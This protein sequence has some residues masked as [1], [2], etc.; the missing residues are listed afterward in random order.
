[1]AIEAARTTAAAGKRIVK[2]HLRDVI[3]GKAAVVPIHGSVEVQITLRQSDDATRNF[4]EWCDFRIYLFQGQDSSEAGRGSI[5]L[6][7]VTDDPVGTEADSDGEHLKVHATGHLEALTNCKLAVSS[8]QFYDTL[9]N[10]GLAFGPT[11]RG[12]KAIRCDGKGAAAAHVDPHA[13]TSKLPD[14]LQLNIIHPGS[15]DATLLQAILVV[16]TKGARKRMATMVPTSI[17]RLQISADLY[18]CKEPAVDISAKREF[19]GSRSADFSTLASSSVDGRVLLYCRL[20]AQT[21]AET[22]LSSS[23]I[24]VAPKQLCYSVEWKPDLGLMTREQIQTYCSSWSTPSLDHSQLMIREKDVLCRLAFE[25]IKK[26]IDEQAIHKRSPHLGRYL[27]WMNNLVLSSDSSSEAYPFIEGSSFD[28][29]ERQV[30]NNDP[31][32]QLMV[33]VTRNLQKIL[34]GEVDAL[35]LLFEDS[36]TNEYYRFFNEIATGFRDLGLYIDLR[37]HKCPTLNILEIGAG[38]GSATRDILRI[39]TQGGTKRFAEYTFTD[40]SASFFAKAR[41]DFRDCV[42]R[43][44][45]L[46]LNIEKDPLQQGFSAKYDIIVASNVSLSHYSSYELV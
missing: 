14:S 4:L 25:R 30:E 46:P 21:I 11:F 22:G 41:E 24:Q 43:M 19:V 45:F 9:K 17:T 42:D 16:L 13:W 7:Y 12:L 8:K 3:F 40:L 27:D 2:Y 26:N 36:L 32:G 6:E 29:L 5:A 23:Q 15:L 18:D 31:A 39:L 1:M 37:A 38:T 35:G 20:K 34:E 28:T 33:R 44:S 10:S